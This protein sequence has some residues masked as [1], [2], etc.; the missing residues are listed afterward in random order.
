MSLEASYDQYKT[1]P[2]L[3]SSL[4]ILKVHGTYGRQMNKDQ[5]LY[6]PMLGFF[7]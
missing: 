4:M 5:G 3:P 7:Y 1:L 6:L 2:L